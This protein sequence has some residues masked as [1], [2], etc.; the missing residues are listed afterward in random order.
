[1]H[2]STSSGPQAH[3]IC[4][5]LASWSSSFTSRNMTTQVWLAFYILILAGQQLCVTLCQRLRL[6]F[7]SLVL[8]LA[9]GG[10]V[11][12]ARSYTNSIRRN[13]IILVWKRPKEIQP[14][15][16]KLLTIVLIGFSLEHFRTTPSFNTMNSALIYKYPYKLFPSNCV[17]DSWWRAT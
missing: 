11:R 13:F 15:K 6:A 12:S 2:E 9:N 4:S 8:T 1:M 3:F 17:L 7:N 16:F 10:I 14:T 5:S